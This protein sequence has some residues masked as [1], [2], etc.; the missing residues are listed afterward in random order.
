MLLAVSACGRLGFE[1]APD[2]VVAPLDAVDTPA[3]CA[4]PRT[5]EFD[6]LPG[7]LEL[8]AAA[9]VMIDVEAGHLR[10]AMPP[11]PEHEGYVVT[12]VESFVGRG[13]ALHVTRVLA[14]GRTSIGLHATASSGHL[15]VDDGTLSADVRLDGGSFTTLA[16]RAYDPVTDAWWRM[17]EDAD[18]LYYETS[19]DGV[20]WRPLAVTTSFDVTS[21]FV[22][23]GCHNGDGLPVA[24]EAHVERMLDCP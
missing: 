22:D 21:T 2:A 15:G 7:F 14:E 12:P 18:V 16:S 19:A 23:F 13:A 20:V 9:A 3:A 17:R 24:D 8:R 6:T 5:T 4:G 1:P 10:I 11:T